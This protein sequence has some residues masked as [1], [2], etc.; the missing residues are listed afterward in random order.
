[1]NN[2]NDSIQSMHMHDIKDN[3]NNPSIFTRIMD[4]FVSNMYPIGIGYLVGGAIGF[5]CGYRHFGRQKEDVV[6]KED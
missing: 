5:Y 4:K 3:I 1:M 2:I 6:M